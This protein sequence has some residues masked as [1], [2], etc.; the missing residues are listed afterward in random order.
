M[1]PKGFKAEYGTD[2]ELLNELN[3]YLVD[4]GISFPFSV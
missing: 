4:A 3:K 1:D 2:L